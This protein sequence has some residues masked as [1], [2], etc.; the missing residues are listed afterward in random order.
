[1]SGEFAGR[2]VVVTGAAGGI[3]RELVRLLAADGA[4]LILH[5]LHVDAL[6][7]LAATLP[8][9]TEHRLVA[10]DVAAPETIAEIAAAA[11]EF[12]G[13][14]GLA[15]AAG[16]YHEVAIAEMTEAQWRQ[17]MS[18][19][20]DA[21]FALT[22]ALLPHL[23]DGAAMVFFTSIAGER[24]SARHAHYAAT[25]GA[26]AAFARSLAAELGP[27]G[28]RANCVA[29]GIIATSMTTDLVAGANGAFEATTP[30]RR[31]G[32]ADEVAEA[33]RFLL[34]PRASFITGVQ[35]DVN[36]GLHMAG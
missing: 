22:S 17:T 14:D 4:Q 3:G 6:D 11:A 34:S 12:G 31:L 27:R 36:G 19:N 2:A 28:V 20:L 13:V 9:A 33:V 24:G 1:M 30:L 5:D 29:P 25:K 7:S 18:I 10:G 16:I 21:V 15:P 23:N 8:P 35:L 32:R 26:L